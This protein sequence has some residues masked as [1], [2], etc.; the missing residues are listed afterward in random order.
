MLWFAE[1]VSWCLF[2]KGTYSW[3]P[4]CLHHCFCRRTNWAAMQ[5]WMCWTVF[6]TWSLSLPFFGQ[7]HKHWPEPLR[8]MTLGGKVALAHCLWMAVNGLIFLRLALFGG[9]ATEETLKA[10]TSKI[11]FC[12]SVPKIWHKSAALRHLL[13]PTLQFS[14]EDNVRRKP[15]FVSFRTFQS[16][17]A[18]LVSTTNSFVCRQISATVADS[19]ALKCCLRL[20][21]RHRLPEQIW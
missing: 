1:P 2:A 3:K 6:W 21:K 9:G 18:W 17:D 10:R 15:Y 4:C 12:E 16:Q 7:L 5:G 8:F 14:L 19:V 13:G 20:T 11:M